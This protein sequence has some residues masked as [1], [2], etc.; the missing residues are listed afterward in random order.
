[1]NKLIPFCLMFYACLS[2]HGQSNN[3]AESG[4]NNKR[5]DNIIKRNLEDKAEPIE[6]L[7]KIIIESQRDPENLP[8]KKKTTEKI[9][10]ELLNRE[11][12]TSGVTANGARYECVKNCRGPFCCAYSEGGRS[13]TH[14]DSIHK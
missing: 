3:S 11:Q 14:P 12:K 9:I 7:E 1:M 6:E 8:K 10:D 2:A 4:V 5:T 13:Y